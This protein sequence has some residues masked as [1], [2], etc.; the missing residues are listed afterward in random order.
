MKEVRECGASGRN[1]TLLTDCYALPSCPPGPLLPAARSRADPHSTGGDHWPRRRARGLLFDEESFR[2][3]LASLLCSPPPLRRPHQ[4]PKVRLQRL[5]D[6][7]QRP[8][9]R[10]CPPLLDRLPAFVVDPRSV[11]GVFLGE[12]RGDADAADLA[13]GVL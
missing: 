1:A 12:L 13:A 7:H 3:L 9:G 8:K 10:I 11:G 5:C 4:H 2:C 6:T